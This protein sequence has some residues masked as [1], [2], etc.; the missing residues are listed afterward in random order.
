MS[1][2]AFPNRLIVLQKIPLLFSVS[3]L[4]FI[5]PAGAEL[6]QPVSSVPT[7]RAKMKGTLQVTKT[8]G[9]EIHEIQT[10]VGTKVREYVSPSGMVFG[11]AWNGQFMPDLQQILGAYFDQYVNA[12]AQG[13]K[14]VRGPVNIQ[15]PGLVIQRG[16][17]Q[18]SFFGRA[19]VPEMIP[20]GASADAVQ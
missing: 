5:L 6:G 15:L 7:D 2:Q 13:K 1:F 4:A 12:V 11:V 17:H 3:L 8:A 14:T 10:A 18:G 16:G 20:P 19:Y 9:Y